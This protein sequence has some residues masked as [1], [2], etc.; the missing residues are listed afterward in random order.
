[1]RIALSI[2]KKRVFVQD[3]ACC[4]SEATKDV[5][6]ADTGWKF[7][8]MASI[9]EIAAS[10]VR[11]KLE[12]IL[13][14]FVDKG[15]AERTSVIEL[16]EFSREAVETKRDNT[17][18]VDGTEGLVR[19]MEDVRSAECL[20]HINLDVALVFI[21]LLRALVEDVGAKCAKM[22]E[23]TAWT[24]VDLCFHNIL[25]DSSPNVKMIC[26]VDPNFN[27]MEVEGYRD[28]LPDRPKAF[29]AIRCRLESRKEV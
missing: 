16:I 24:G 23:E 8:R 25:L 26:N 22:V 14:L 12:E 5:E 10:G 17:K 4:R 1:M 18:L 29:D 20:T 9:D 6:E 27:R 19:E 2:D 28:V 3:T 15:V 11:G 13:A 7:K 21:K